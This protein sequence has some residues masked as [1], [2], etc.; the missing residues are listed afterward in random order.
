VREE[1][2]IGNGEVSEVRESVREG[3]KGER[4]GEKKR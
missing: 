4:G 2:K 3:Q 1:G